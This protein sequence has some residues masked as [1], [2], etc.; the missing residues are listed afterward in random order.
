MVRAEVLLP[1]PRE[2]L[3]SLPRPLRLIT[4]V[5]PANTGMMPPNLD[6]KSRGTRTNRGFIATKGDT[7]YIGVVFAATVGDAAVALQTLGVDSAINLDGG[8]SSALFYNGKY[9]VGPGRNLPN[10]VI[11]AR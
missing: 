1:I 3:L 4:I 11:L 2:H 5:L 8:G 9:V 7:L 6:E 10:A